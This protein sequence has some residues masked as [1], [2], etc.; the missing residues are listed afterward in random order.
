MTRIFQHIIFFIFKRIE[1]RCLRQYRWAAINPP[2]NE[3]YFLTLSFIVFIS[4]S[5]FAQGDIDLKRKYIEQFKWIALK[6]MELTGIPASIKLAQGL[7][8]S[9]AGI[10]TLATV[11]NNHFG[12]KCHNDWTGL[13]FYKVDDDKDANGKLIPSCFRKFSSAEESYHAHSLWLTKRPRY[14]ALF[15]LEPTD[16]K[17]WAHGLKKAGY[18][19][20]PAYGEKL[21]SIIEKFELHKIQPI[22]T[23]SD[24]HLVAHTE[25][26]GREIVLKKESIK[27]VAVQEQNERGVWIMNEVRFVYAK[28]GMKLSEISEKYAIPLKKLIAYNPFLLDTLTDNQPV[29]LEPKRNSF[30]GKQQWHIVKPNESLQHI[31]DYYAI[32]KEALRKRNRLF[33][34][35]EPTIGTRLKLNGK[36]IK[37]IH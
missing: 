9:S 6:E 30:K 7:L 15:T 18:A 17:G 21:I 5:M 3:K 26:K 24:I 31:A 33:E 34:H 16:Y 35:E 11:A 23:P 2:N 1:I 12:M 4:S 22:I 27:S 37:W 28:Q 36:K 20:D 32:N 8:E 14:S 29:F 10:S 25:K 13:T 19:T